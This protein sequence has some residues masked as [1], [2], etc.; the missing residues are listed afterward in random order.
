MHGDIPEHGA[1]E[2]DG[3]GVRVVGVVALGLKL[4]LLAH[5]ELGDDGRAVPVLE[6][7]DV[8][9]VQVL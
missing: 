9:G 4:E 1:V 2:A 7:G 8:E 5:L 6:S 3:D